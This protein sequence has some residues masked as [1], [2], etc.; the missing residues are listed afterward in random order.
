M[1]MFVTALQI[2]PEIPGQK[3]S[4]QALDTLAGQGIL[5]SLCVL[6]IVALFV[7]IKALLKA[8]DDRFADQKLMTETLE[9]HNQAAKELAVEMNK[10]ASSL[11]VESTKNMDSMKN[12]L[13][14]QER[15]MD[16]LARTITALQQ[17]GM[18]LR[19]AVA[20]FKCSGSKG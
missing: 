2:G 3:Q 15:S 12:T 17:E 8:K 9:R 10:A 20:N 11:V 1:V 5:G 16:D 4:E 7:T 19:V 18:Q 13:S 6:L 14:A